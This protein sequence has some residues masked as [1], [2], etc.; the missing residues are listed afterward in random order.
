MFEPSQ[1]F[2]IEK[3]IS[4]RA[5]QVEALSF[6]RL[7]HFNHQR[8]KK[9]LETERGEREKKKRKRKKSTLLIN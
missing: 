2:H 3:T 1:G 9:V 5:F 8:S 6:H 4:L 7:L